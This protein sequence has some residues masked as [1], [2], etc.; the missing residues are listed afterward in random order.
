MIPGMQKS[1]T[2]RGTPRTTFLAAVLV[3]CTLLTWT[4]PAWWLGELICNLRIQGLIAIA[5][6]GGVAAVRRLW[7]HVGLLALCLVANGWWLLPGD[8]VLTADSNEKSVRI[9]TAN[10]LTSNHNHQLIVEELLRSDA[11]VIGV[12]ELSFG[13]AHIFKGGSFAE[14]YPYSITQPNSDGNFGIGLYSRFPLVNA[15]VHD[16][17]L[18]D[19]PSMAAD[20]D[21][22]GQTFHVIATHVLAPMGS[23]WYR[24]RR[25]HLDELAAYI[26]DQRR[27]R[28]AVPVIVFGD[29]NLT[30]WSPLL[31]DFLKKSGLKRTTSSVQ[32]TWHAAPVFAAGLHIDL[33]LATDDVGCGPIVIGQSM[34]SDHLPVTADFSRID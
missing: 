11:D 3:V 7:K 12:P 23:R 32:P 26:Q 25:E 16:F 15:R 8:S 20:I 19:I 5:V 18:A 27:Q 14:E 17:P 22:N 9:C 34:K 1:N 33:I 10:I 28:P 6:V 29:F 2:Q 31:Y 13:Q 21:A 4:A 24:I 30:P